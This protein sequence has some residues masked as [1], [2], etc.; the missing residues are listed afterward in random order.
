[1]PR[2]AGMENTFAFGLVG[3]GHMWL[4]AVKRLNTSVQRMAMAVKFLKRG[5]F[6]VGWLVGYVAG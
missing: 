6:L 4:K 1:M 5:G 3:C 2:L